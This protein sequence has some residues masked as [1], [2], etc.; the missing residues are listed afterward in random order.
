MA[1]L[2]Q[3]DRTGPHEHHVWE[4]TVT[5]YHG[6]NGIPADICAECGHHRLEGGDMPMSHERWVAFLAWLEA[7]PTT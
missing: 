4:E 3:C 6:C 1:D 5:H 2:R 7:N